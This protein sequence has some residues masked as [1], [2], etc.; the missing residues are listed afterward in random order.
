MAA[1]KATTA[2][3]KSLALLTEMVLGSQSEMSMLPIR[4]LPKF[5][6]RFAIFVGWESILLCCEFLKMSPGDRTRK[7]VE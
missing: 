7:I 3:R 6:I 2:V 5:A 1:V 4:L